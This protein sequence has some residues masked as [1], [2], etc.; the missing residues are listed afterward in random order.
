MTDPVMLEVRGLSIE[1]QAR[2]GAVKALRNVSFAVRRG[3]ALALIGE[4]GS[5]KT[6]L[7]LSLVRLLASSARVS[8]G[9]IIFSRPGAAGGAATAVDVL[10][11]TPRQLR[12]FRWSECAMVFQAA[13]NAFNPVLRIADQFADTARAHGYLRG[14]ALRDRAA[15]LLR[16]VRLDPDRVWRAYPHELSGGM[17]QRVLDRARPTPSSR[18][19]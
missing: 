6:T 9:Q 5:G 18:R 2:R 15:T 7:G 3:E 8:A 12:A 14:A 13:L 11:L 16:Q 10:D 19:C 4:S 1:Y 17:R